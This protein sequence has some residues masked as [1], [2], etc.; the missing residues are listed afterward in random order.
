MGVFYPFRARLLVVP[1]YGSLIGTLRGRQVAVPSGR[2]V[3]MARSR[4]LLIDYNRVIR[5]GLKHILEEHDYEVVGEVD[6]LNQVEQKVKELHPDLIFTDVRSEK[7]D[8]VEATRIAKVVRPEAVVI[9]LTSLD[10]GA[11]ILEAI[12][13]GASAYLLLKDLTSEMLV[14]TIRMA[15]RSGTVVRTELLRSITMSL[16]STALSNL[17]FIRGGGGTFSL[18]ER[19]SE[20]LALIANGE[21]NR[22]IASTL[23]IQ[24]DTTKKYVKSV[25]GKIGARNRTHAA[26]MAARAG[27]AIRPMVTQISGDGHGDGIGA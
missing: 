8:G 19:E 10:N 16:R 3:V 5:A 6:D 18:T 15:Q 11:Y 12:N 17:A 21:S 4:V 25:I 20:V 9:I 22:S 7:L 23:G 13:A 14:E 24:E 27:L 26:I 1:R 2:S